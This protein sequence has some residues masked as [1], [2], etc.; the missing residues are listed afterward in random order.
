MFIPLTTL[1]LSIIGI[2]ITLLISPFI[3]MTIFLFFKNL[4]II[5]INPIIKYRNKTL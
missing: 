5:R 2:I 3:G 4:F 1:Y